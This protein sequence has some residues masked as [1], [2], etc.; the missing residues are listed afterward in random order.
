MATR[1]NP[2]RNATPIHV[3]YT[4][5]MMIRTMLTVLLL[6]ACTAIP[7]APATNTPIAIP[8]EIPPGAV[9]QIPLDAAGTPEAFPMLFVR[10]QIMDEVTGEPVR[11]DVYVTG[12]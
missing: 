5:F 11:A 8:T 2:P 1:Q 3:C 10:S 6:A 12:Q 7:A 4:G 9:V